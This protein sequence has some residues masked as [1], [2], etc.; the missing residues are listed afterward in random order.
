MNGYGYNNG[1]GYGYNNW[2]TP[3]S[4]GQQNVM[5]NNSFQNNTQ[6]VDTSNSQNILNQ[7]AWVNGEVG[8]QAFQIP[9]GMSVILMDSD[10]PMFYIKTSDLSGKASIKAFKYE[11]YNATT[12]APKIDYVTK[13][14]FEQF[15]QSILNKQEE[16]T[17]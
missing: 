17:V 6:T 5:P 2:S 3:T 12:T 16:Q 4:Y 10:N 1:Y 15:K 14:E 11:E 13:E 9:R 7:V 8:A